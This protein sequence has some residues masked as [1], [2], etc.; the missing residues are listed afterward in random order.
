MLARVA[1]GERVGTLFRA[2]NRIGSR[3]HWLAF[4]AKPRGRSLLDDG[5]VRALRERGR[6]LLP[7]GIVRVEG[8]FGI[9]DPVACVDVARARVR[10]RARRLRGRRGPSHQGPAHGQIAQVLGYSNGD[11]VIHRDDLVLLGDTPLETT[12][13]T[14][15]ERIEALRPRRRRRVARVADL[16][17]ARRTPGCCARPSASKRAGAHPRREPRGHA[18][19]RRRTASRRRS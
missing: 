19:R 7:A 5:A 11:E 15:R 6:S 17:T 13:M 10:A 18:A 16:G 14:S 2:G 12:R 1:A 9:G 4:T 3:K 8:R